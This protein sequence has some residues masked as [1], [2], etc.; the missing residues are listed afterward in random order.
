MFI[1]LG[2]FYAFLLLLFCL[3]FNIVFFPEVRAPLLGSDD[4]LKPYE[5]AVKSALFEWNITEK[6][7]NIYPPIQS[8]A[9]N[10][11]KVPPPAPIEQK[12]TPAASANVPKEEPKESKPIPDSLLP[13]PPQKD[14]LKSKPKTVPDIEKPKEPEK[15]K[16]AV[17]VA[18]PTENQQTAVVMPVPKPAAA[19]ILP[20]V[21]DQFKPLITAPKQ[22]FKPT[23]SIKPSASAV[24]DTVDTALERPIRYDR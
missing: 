11:Q 5:Q 14:E 1:R 4:P 3:S 18:T 6:I 16:P 15:P 13:T 8:N 2:Q 9:E 21:A 12:N 24:W 10:I 23:E 20:V 17:P 19:I 7:S 22:A